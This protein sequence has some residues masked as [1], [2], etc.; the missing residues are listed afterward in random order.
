[1]LTLFAPAKVNLTLEVLGKRDDGF[2]E[3]KSVIQTVSLGD[4]LTFRISENVECKSDMSDWTPE[5]SLVSKAVN[6][7]H[8]ETS[9]RKGVAI[10]IRKSIPLSAGLGG[11]SSDAAATLCGLN[12]LWGLNLSREQ[13]ANIGAKLGSDVPLFLYGG[14]VL[15]E[16][17]GEKVSELPPYPHMWLVILIPAV[18]TGKTK[19]A[20]A[21]SLLKPSHYTEGGATDRLVGLI[22][23][24]EDM[25][26]MMN[27]FSIGKE[28]FIH[29]P[30]NVFESIAFD[31]YQ[32]LDRYWQKFTQVGAPAVHLTGTGPALYTLTESKEEADKIYSR[33]K[34]QGLMC[35]LAQ[36]L[37]STGMC[38]YES[39]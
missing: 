2:H 38:R 32:G 17:R 31:C 21:Y 33:L 7:L 24:M 1:M 23:G 37:R 12:E 27:E 19:T 28:R 15:V 35:Y 11:D 18:A 14:T 20:Q 26:M 13:L 6:L 34:E 16:G 22:L 10:E 36:T 5:L 8:R 29:F 3:I 30:S 39:Q 9:C 4:R 25:E